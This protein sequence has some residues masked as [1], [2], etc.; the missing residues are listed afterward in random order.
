MQYNFTFDTP[1]F[2]PS[3]KIQ[4][5]FSFGVDLLTSK[6]P[7][8]RILTIT[9][10]N[11]LVDSPFLVKNYC[12]E[13]QNSCSSFMYTFETFFCFH[14]TRT[15]CCLQFSRTSH[16]C[17]L[18][19]IYCDEMKYVCYRLGGFCFLMNSNDLSQNV[20]CATVDSRQTS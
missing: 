7:V 1:D 15:L 11:I 8:F 10:Y 4:H 3:N 5:C 9:I 19:V 17:H 14:K 2:S 13:R 6:E 20:Q 12:I 16:S 18:L